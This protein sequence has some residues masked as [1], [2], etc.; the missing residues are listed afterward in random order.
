MPGERS[1]RRGGW[2]ANGASPS[3]RK[4]GE[5]Q[6]PQRRWG[7]NISTQRR[8]RTT[9]WATCLH[10][11]QALRQGGSWRSIDNDYVNQ[12]ANVDGGGGGVAL[13]RPESD[14]GLGQSGAENAVVCSSGAEADLHT[15]LDVLSALSYPNSSIRSVT[16]CLSSLCAS[17]ASRFAAPDSP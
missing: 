13:R 15:Q 9:V 16:V 3:S 4:H 5:T 12:E 10:T 8:E 14:A 11:V 17:M 6:Q 1:P 2:A 7:S